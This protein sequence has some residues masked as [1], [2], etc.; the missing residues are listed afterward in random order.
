MLPLPE[1]L[2][3]TET[4][5]VPEFAT[6][7]SGLPSPSRSP[8]A[9]EKGFVP[10][11]KSTLVAKSP[12]VMVDLAGSY[13]GLKLLRLAHANTVPVFSRVMGP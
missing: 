5:F 6:A 8:M 3:K 7:R 4:V 1:V 13:T 2:R 12:L 11:V 9:T 10:A